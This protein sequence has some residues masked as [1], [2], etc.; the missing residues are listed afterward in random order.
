MQTTPRTRVACRQ[1]ISVGGSHE[2]E[3]DVHAARHD[4]AYGVRQRT[5]VDE[6]VIDADLAQ[7]VGTGQVA[8]GADDL[9][10]SRL[11]STAAA[12]PTLDVAP[13]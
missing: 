5:V 13:R 6:D 12:M 2:V 9:D 7:P 8:G 3:S 4:L 1:S 10:P 11:A